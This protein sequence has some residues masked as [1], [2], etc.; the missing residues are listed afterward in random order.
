MATTGAGRTSEDRGILGRLGQWC[1]FR[2]TGEDFSKP[3]A[4][5][6]IISWHGA[7]ENCIFGRSSS[8]SDV[9]S[10]LIMVLPESCL[11]FCAFHQLPPISFSR[12]DLCVICTEAGCRVNHRPTEWESLGT[13]LRN[14]QFL[15]I[16]RWS[17]STHNLKH[18]ACGSPQG[19]TFQFFTSLVSKGLSSENVPVLLS[20]VCVMNKQQPPKDVLILRICDSY[21]IKKKKRTLQ[22]WLS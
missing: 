11:R 13:E 4:S 15:Q 16:A 8:N 18:I 7:Q 20:L 19:A 5:R 1:S 21:M 22:I 6:I 10:E 17:L 12:C 3:Q 2:I 9:Y 14:T